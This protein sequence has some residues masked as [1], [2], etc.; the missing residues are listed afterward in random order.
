MVGLAGQ[1]FYFAYKHRDDEN[2]NERNKL[3]GYGGSATLCLLMLIA[4]LIKLCKYNGDVKT[5][6]VSPSVPSVAIT[7]TSVPS[8][9]VPIVAITPTSVTSVPSD[10]TQSK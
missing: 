2:K 3:L 4:L 1:S 5:K 10:S 6:V 9:S 8:P 7:P